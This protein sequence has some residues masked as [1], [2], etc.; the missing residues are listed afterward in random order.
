[1]NL[2]YSSIISKKKTIDEV[3]KFFIEKKISNIELT[4]GI[5]YDENILDKLI[6]YKKNYNL[7]L[8]I[9]N[10]FPS[11]KKDFVINLSS[12]DNEIYNLSLSHCIKA[13]EISKKIKATKYAF[14][15]GFLLDLEAEETGNLIKR[16]KLINRNNA[17]NRLCEAFT[18]LVNFSAGE[19]DLFIENNV[20]T[21]EN[22]NNFSNINPF[23]L[24]DKK[25]YLELKSFI[26]FNIL[27]DLG[28]LNVSS[29][30]LK[31]DIN[32]ETN[33]FLQI[34]KYIHF[35][36]NNKLKDENLAFSNDNNAYRHLLKNKLDTKT[37][38]L[39]VKSD[40]DQIEKLRDKFLK[41]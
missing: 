7:N 40:F 6:F 35:S 19:V 20:V 13:I 21:L 38:T 33:F 16:R 29:E 5:Q 27:L 37:I 41:L 32:D 22:Y 28:H 31:L 25:S 23:L 39:E 11:P 9:H 12:L 4:G 14:H 18:K 10:Y 17:I 15:A 3:F 34:A 1:M 24:T 8:L 2:F 30:T 36:E 26:D